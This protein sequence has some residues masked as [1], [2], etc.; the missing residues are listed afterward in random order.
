E[1]PAR[2]GAGGQDG[3]NLLLVVRLAI[4]R[5]ALDPV[6]LGVVE[7]RERLERLAAVDHRERFAEV[8]ADR[9]GEVEAFALPELAG[10]EVLAVEPYAVDGSVHAIEAAPGQNGLRL[11]GKPVRL[12]ELDAGQDSQVLEPRPAALHSFEVALDVNSVLPLVHQGP[13]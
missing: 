11:L 13:V 3:A 9:G 1:H 12:A 4:G 10:V 5:G 7:V 8:G 6:A 2:A